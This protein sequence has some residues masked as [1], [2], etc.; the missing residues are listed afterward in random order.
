M[1]ECFHAFCVPLFSQREVGPARLC[2]SGGHLFTGF[3]LKTCGNDRWS[4]GFALIIEQIFLPL[5]HERHPLLFHPAQQLIGCDVILEQL[6]DFVAA[7][8][9]VKHL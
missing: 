3:P 6:P 2:C 4:R 9:L 8:H 7:I 5:P 1:P